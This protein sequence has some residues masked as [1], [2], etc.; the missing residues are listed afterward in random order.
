MD[1]S[2]GA[3]F[4]IF[5]IFPTLL[6]SQSKGKELKV[7][8]ESSDYSGNTSWNGD[9][10]YFAS[11]VENTVVIWNALSDSVEK[12]YSNLSN[13]DDSSNII[14]VEYSK[15][16]QYL[17]SVQ[18][19]KN[20]VLYST[21]LGV[22]VTMISGEQNSSTVAALS[23]G[24]YSIILPVDNK[25]L[26]E[27]LRLIET[28][29]Y[30]LSQKLQLDSEI[31]FLSINNEG[32]RIL[33]SSPNGKAF[34]I[35]VEK[36]SWQIIQTYDWFA[37]DFCFPK[38]SSDGKKF[39]LPK[40][41]NEIVI[42]SFNEENEDPTLKSINL[43]QNFI[44]DACFSNDGKFITVGTDDG[45]INIFDCESSEIKYA[46]SLDENEIPTKL[47]FSPD[48]NSVLITTKTG[49]LYRWNLVS[50]KYQKKTDTKLQ[51]SLFGKEK[52]DEK[53]G[54]NSEKSQSESANT[55]NQNSSDFSGENS[56]KT[57]NENAFLGNGEFSTRHGT[58]ADVFV[59]VGTSPSPFVFSA[60]ATFDVHL[61]DI[62]KPFYIGG[63]ITPF[64]AF[65][66]S[67][68]PYTYMLVDEKLD[69]PVMIGGNLCAVIGLFVM[70][71]TNKDFGLSAEILL[72]GGIAAI[73][74]GKLGAEG[75]SSK[76]FPSVNVGTKLG[77]TWKF[78]NVYVGASYDSVQKVLV[79]GGLGANFKLKFGGKKNE[80][81]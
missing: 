26:Y 70:P 47:S 60:Q 51:D 33:A 53:S 72:G 38:I 62:L 74:N 67:D 23:S 73:W 7:L 46:V 3:F 36:D 49:R 37:N 40:S 56:G 15:N 45:K 61:Y 14:S 17:L 28:K 18:K 79:N 13:G 9:G 68:F 76:I 20:I 42:A 21:D 69:S 5:L 35:F 34:F 16:G 11:A 77:F 55:K 75:I 27:Y 6:Y 25:N 29:K 24:G 78:I 52:S 31:C 71:F 41:Q 65:P 48:G 4:I 32:N 43:S 80:S 66:S 10:S 63:Q 30:I 2:K 8:V 1:F 22:P 64:I 57:T 54:E 12:I 59:G 50:V 44:S 81:E 39:L 58:Y 19:N